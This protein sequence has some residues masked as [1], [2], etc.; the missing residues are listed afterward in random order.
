MTRV[1]GGARV[2][3]RK[4]GAKIAVAAVLVA[5]LGG[6]AGGG[7]TD[8]GS[9]TKGSASSTGAAPTSSLPAPTPTAEAPTAQAE[10]IIVLTSTN[11]SCVVHAVNPETGEVSAV[12]TF[13]KNASTRNC[14][15]PQYKAPL[16]YSSTF[17]RIAATQGSGNDTRA[18]WMTTDGTFVQVGPDSLNP[19]FGEPEVVHD[20]G[21]DELDNFYYTVTEGSGPSV[22]LPTSYYRVPAGQTG[23]GELVG[24]NEDDG[25]FG[26]LPGGLLGTGAQEAIFSGCSLNIRPSRDFNPDVAQYFHAYKNQVFRS[27]EW[28]SNNGEPI[29]DAAKST[30]LNIAVSP[31]GDQVAMQTA[32]SDFYV[33]AASGAGT[34]R[35]LNVPE[36]EDLGGT[37]WVI[38]S[39][40]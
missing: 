31:Q 2:V 4:R 30:V 3:A 8:G 26:R 24:T 7:N 29:T 35:K 12:S 5:S 33:T 25:Y 32:L 23:D 19:D 13:E 15:E 36:F 21:F 40:R 6:C 34:P 1:D 18:G 17:D 11:S 37:G 27:A 38:H 28:C 10:G 9:S 14:R 16:V 22:R 39:W 20:V